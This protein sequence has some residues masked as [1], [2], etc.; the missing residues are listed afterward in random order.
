[1]VLKIFST[2][3]VCV[4]LLKLKTGET[5]IKQKTLPNTEL[6]QYS[7]LSNPGLAYNRGLNS[8]AW[9]TEYVPSKN[10]LEGPIGK[11]QVWMYYEGK[12]NTEINKRL[13]KNW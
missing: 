2:A 7:T 10:L 1:M 6:N 3:Y 12:K 4:A 13:S 11:R 8:L 9:G 5:T